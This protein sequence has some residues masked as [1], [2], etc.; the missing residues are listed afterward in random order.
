MLQMIRQLC[1]QDRG[2]LTFEWILLLT[3][4]VI[5]VVGALSA[6]RDATISELGDVAGSVIAID[7]SFS[8]APDP[9]IGGNGIV[10]VDPTEPLNTC[11]PDEAPVGAGQGGLQ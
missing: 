11:R 3:L 2:V 7:Q 6:V 5:G 4:L 8:V 9:C 1:R 10:Y